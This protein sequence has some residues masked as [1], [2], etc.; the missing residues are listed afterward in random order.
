MEYSLKCDHRQLIKKA[1]PSSTRKKNTDHS[2]NTAEMPTNSHR[3]I[4]NILKRGVRHRPGELLLELTPLRF[5]EI[6]G[7]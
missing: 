1:S 3:P 7:H 5:S 6:A 2:L 4:S